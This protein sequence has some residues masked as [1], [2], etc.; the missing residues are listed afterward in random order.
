LPARVEALEFFDAR[1]F[2]RELGVLV[3]R[4]DPT[5]AAGIVRRILRMPSFCWGNAYGEVAGRW[6]KVSY[7]RT[8][9]NPLVAC[10]GQVR[11]G[12]IITREIERIY[13]TREEI[14]SRIKE[15]LGDWGVFNW[16]RD[17]IA[18]GMSHPLKWMYDLIV[19]DQID[20]VRDR[21]NMVIGDF[22]DMTGIR[23]GHVIT[24]LHVRNV[25]STSF[26][27]LSLGKTTVWFIVIG[28]SGR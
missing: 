14:E 9:E 19:G 26:E 3:K 25:T 1:A 21:V 5:L 27:F 11:A 22:Y 6:Y 24:P 15:S 2:A 12:D 8:I 28:K 18:W 16:M 23:R 4:L 13:L 7:P 10:V 17:A 20:R